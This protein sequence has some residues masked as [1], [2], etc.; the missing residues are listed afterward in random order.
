MK[1]LFAFLVLAAFL[2]GFEA[3]SAILIGSLSP[4]VTLQ[5]NTSAF[6]TNTAYIA[7]P[8]FSVSN[9]GLVIT[10]AYTG[11]FRFSVDNGTTWFTNNS[12]QFNPAVTNAGTT[13]INAQTIQVPVQIQLT[14]ITNAANT[15]TI[16][17]GVTSP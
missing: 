15:S 5:T 3:Q 2:A 12:P 13:V 6:L 17:I 9:N 16:Q 1:K 10:N 7:V 14:A 4:I 11:S 8:Q